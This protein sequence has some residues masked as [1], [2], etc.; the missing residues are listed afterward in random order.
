ASLKDHLKGWCEQNGVTFDTENVLNSNQDTAI[1]HDLWNIEKHGKLNRP[2]R[3]GFIPR[4]G[5][6][7]LEMVNP[8][9]KS[10]SESI[11]QISRNSYGGADF[12]NSKGEKLVA[13]I[14]AKVL[15][16]NNAELG[17]VLDICES[18][19]SQWRNAYQAAG[20]RVLL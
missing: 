8:D 16:D 20:V 2:P 11:S 13:R 3:S 4:I 10:T 1:I 6:I 18:A 15:S 14:R 9:G 19:I 7:S 5:P 17:D 12:T